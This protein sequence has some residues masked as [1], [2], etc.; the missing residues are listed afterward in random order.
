[1]HDPSQ[2]REAVVIVDWLGRGGIAHTTEAWVRE[3]AVRGQTTTVVTRA[4]RELDRLVPDRIG[5]GG[6]GGAIIGHAEVVQAAIRAV[7][8]QTKCTVVLQ[9]SVLPQ[10]ELRLARSAR[11]GGNQVVLV[12]HESS[13]TR[14][15][16]GRMSAFVRLIRSADIV[17]A[18]SSFVAE[19]L[20]RRTGRSDIEVVPLPLPLGLLDLLGTAPSVLA[21][22]EEAVAVH[23]G[24]LHRD[25]KGSATVQALAERTVPGWRFALVGKGAPARA[26]GAETVGRFLDP[27]EL[28]A[29]VAGSDATLL[30]YVRASQSAAVVLAQALGSPVIASAVGGIPE[31]IEHGATGWLVAPGAPVEVWIDAL[32]ALADPRER[33]RLAAA[34]ASSVQSAHQRFVARIIE[35][36]P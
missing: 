12:A 36:L 2:N 4:G 27:A 6:R 28:V 26:T 34:A 17:I 15:S 23:F 29:T 33:Q 22:S 1:M 18:H 3:R 11:D 19:E 8:E 20:L 14:R 10:L 13:V 31:Q 5:A 30:P 21:P 32:L 7:R 16:P 35:L 24:N 9:G 25:Y